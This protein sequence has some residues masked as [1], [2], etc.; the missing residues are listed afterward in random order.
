MGGAP[1]RQR[2]LYVGA[3]RPCGQW[4]WPF[5]ADDL[6]ATPL[7]ANGRVYAGT[8]G[9]HVYAVRVMTGTLIRR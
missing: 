1:L 9:G 7:L 6:V 5:R 4:P 2:T 3:G 8:R